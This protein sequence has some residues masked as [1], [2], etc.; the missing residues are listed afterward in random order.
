MA[1]T[2]RGGPSPGIIRQVR[3]TRVIPPVALLAA[4]SACTQH[5]PSFNPTPHP[6][7]PGQVVIIAGDRETSRTPR[8]GEYAVRVNVRSNGGL[9]VD[10]GTGR[11]YVPIAGDGGRRIARIEADGRITMLPV[12]IAD[13]QLAVSGDHLWQMASYAGLE[14]SRT[15][16]SSLRTTDVLESDE[17]TDPRFK[18]LDRHGEP[19]SATEADRLN[20]NWRGSQFALSGTGVPI[21]LS[22]AGQLF[23]VVGRNVLKRWEPPGYEAALRDLGGAEDFHATEL[24]ADGPHGVIALGRAGLLRV[25]AD[26]GV[27][28]TEFPRSA[29][30]APPW[31]AALPLSGGAVLLLGGVS[32][33]QGSPRPALI[34][35]DGDLQSLSLGLQREC[36]EFDGSM[37]DVASADPGGASKGRD[38]SYIMLNKFCG[39]IYSFRLPSHLTSEP[40]RQ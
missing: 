21:V 4:L 37:A 6:T 2:A 20:K 31:T 18:I 34:T 30:T 29:K 8:D 9:T 25:G 5:T 15:S 23:E 27:R 22:R 7:R 40:Y 17:E 32:P 24:V 14:L 19:L 36:D 10:Q 1:H 16:L 38:G 33:L 28:A 35:P 3:Y 26:G 12:G 11:I 13:A 39:V